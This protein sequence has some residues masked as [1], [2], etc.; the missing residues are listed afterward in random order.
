MASKDLDNLGSKSSSLKIVAGFK[1]SQE[2]F[3]NFIFDGVT[4][5]LGW[6]HSSFPGPGN[7]EWIFKFLAKLRF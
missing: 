7:L 2:S 1:A 3:Y 4:E 5:D 6:L